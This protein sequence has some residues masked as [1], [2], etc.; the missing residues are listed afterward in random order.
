MPFTQDTGT[1]FGLS[2]DQLVLRTES[3]SIAA[4]LA[5]MLI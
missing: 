4:L 1:A 2:T 5:R 3:L